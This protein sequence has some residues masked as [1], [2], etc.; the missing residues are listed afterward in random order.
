[1][2]WD[3]A[4]AIRVFRQHNLVGCDVLEFEGLLYVFQ[5]DSHDR[6]HGAP[7]A[8]GMV[9]QSMPT[10]F[11]P[12]GLANKSCCRGVPGRNSSFTANMVRIAPAEAVALGNT[13]TRL[14]PRQ[15]WSLTTAK[16]LPNQP[17]FANQP[18]EGTPGPHGIE[19][20][21]RYGK[22]LRETDVEIPN[23]AGESVRQLPFPKNALLK[24]KLADL[25]ASYET[26]H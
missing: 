20:K 8:A 22:K 19:T 26:G 21:C 11:F 5:G 14:H 24:F 10:S 9:G 6:N 17:I 18:V 25:K 23:Q 12:L 4:L 3:V 2:R 13:G 15:G 7:G 1:M 16:W